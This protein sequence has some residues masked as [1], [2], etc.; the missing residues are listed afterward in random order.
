MFTLLHIPNILE[1]GQYLFF[2]MEGETGHRPIT[3]TRDNSGFDSEGWEPGISPP[4]VQLFPPK[5]LRKFYYYREI[6]TMMIYTNYVN[7]S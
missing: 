1:Q 2:S 7:C 6:S 4:K 5:N 3:G